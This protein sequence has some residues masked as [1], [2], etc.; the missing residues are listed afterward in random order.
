VAT[1]APTVTTCGNANGSVKLTVT[2]G[3]GPYTYLWN[4]GQ[5]TDP[6]TALAAGPYQVT[7]T[8]AGGCTTTASATVPAS[9]AVS[10]TINPTHTT[11]GNSNGQAQATVTTGV[12]PYTYLWNNGQSTDNAVNLASGSYQLTI[13]DANNCT[14]I[15]GTVINPSSGLVL[16]V[17]STDATCGSLDGQADVQVT[18]GTAP[19]SY[20]WDNG[21]TNSTATGLGAGTYTVTVTG[22][23]GCTATGTANVSNLNGPVINLI[24]TN[25]ETCFGKNDGDVT[26]TAS[27]G[28]G[29]LTML[30]GD[31]NTAFSRAALA[32]GSYNFSV[33]DAS[34]CVAT[35]TAI[36]TPGGL[37]CPL[38]TS[39]SA[40]AP[41][42][43]ASDGTITVNITI[44]GTGPYQ[45]KLDNGALQGTN[46]FSNLSGGVYSTITIDAGGCSD[47]VSVTVP[48]APASFTAQVTTVATTCG[49]NDGSATVTTSGTTG[50]VSYAWDNGQI[51]STAVS[52]APGSYTV[53][54]SDAASG[55]TVTQTGVVPAG[56]GCCSLQ[57]SGTSTAPSCGAT[58]GT[59]TIN[60]VTAGTTPYTYSINGGAV[61]NGNT[62]SNLTGGNYQVIVVDAAGCR[63]TVDVVVAPAPASF[64]S[65]ISS[66]DISCFGAA[67]GDAAVSVTGNTGTISYVWS[68]GGGGTAI[69]NLV[70]G[71]YTVT[72]S[73]GGSAC[74]AVE[75]ATIAEP[76]QL[77]VAIS[78]NVSAC[79]GDSVLLT[80]DAG[81]SSYVW[82]TGNAAQAISA[83]ASGFY[84]VTITDVNNCSASSSV[85]VT[86]NNAPTVSLGPDTV[87]FENDQIVLQPVVSGTSNA[88]GYQWSPATNLNCVLCANPVTVVKD[89]ITY[90]L[91]YTDN[92]GC[93][94]YDTLSIFMDKAFEIEFPNVFSP[95]GDNANDFFR[96]EGGPLK[97]LSWQVYN[98]WGEKVYSTNELF[99][100]WDG[101]YLGIDQPTGVYVYF[102][103]YTRNDGKK[104]TLQGSLTLI[105]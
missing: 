87:A 54:V 79:S 52:L 100:G 46:V 102:C 72:I 81:F 10:A 29:A 2:S 61:Q 71:T 83:G 74:T 70:A 95:N 6:A 76:A 1:A 20:L 42:C 58:D 59:I 90:V 21:Q 105:R 63:D 77:N 97:N 34:N 12:A 16:S 80:A 96:P 9:Q 18:A 75:S 82:S 19:Y 39:A 98:R 24:D 33:T 69:G 3:T 25:A 99:L 13:A 91:H 94:A 26:V 68:N 88:N 38:Q 14:A 53:T 11:C 47:T 4:N 57:V 56:P 41:T 45:Y 32:P 8:G 31:G 104:K 37:C 78:G 60:T 27:G 51:T 7:V 23:G 65:S 103:S 50:T 40:T 89:S 67:D 48:N 66:N 84:D 85:Q 86:I 28:T 55:C 17:T 93:D 22:T 15:V 101:K 64:T 35:G 44:P 30:W 5:T 49:N 62:F 73:E 36:I 43:G 92:N